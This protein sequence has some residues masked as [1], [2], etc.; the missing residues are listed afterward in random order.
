MLLKNTCLSAFLFSIKII[1][2]REY[3]NTQMCD[4]WQLSF[5]KVKLFSI[6]NRLLI[7]FS[8]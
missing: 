1:S 6:L 7:Y 4:Y 2:F 8:K 3:C 5:E